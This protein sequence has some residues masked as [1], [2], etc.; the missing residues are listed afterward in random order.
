MTISDNYEI[1]Q[2]EGNRIGGI[3]PYGEKAG[4]TP[5]YFPIDKMEV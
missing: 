4:A 2:P 1:I 3:Q 5:T